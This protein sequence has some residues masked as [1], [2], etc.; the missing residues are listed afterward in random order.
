MPRWRKPPRSAASGER[1]ASKDGPSKPSHCQRG[2][3]DWSRLPRETST[4]MATT[5]ATQGRSGF[6]SGS[7]AAVGFHGLGQSPQLSR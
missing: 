5:K 2:L 3:G 6:H 4:S 1:V 7:V